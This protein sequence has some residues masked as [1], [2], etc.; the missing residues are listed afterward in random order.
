M[1]RLLLFVPLLGACPG[2]PSQ[3]ACGRLCQELV[4]NCDYAAYPTTESCLQGCGYNESQGA[5]VDGQ[6]ACVAEA[7]CDTFAIVECEHTYGP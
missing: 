6:E 7:A 4:V 5:D 1:S 3:T 2:A